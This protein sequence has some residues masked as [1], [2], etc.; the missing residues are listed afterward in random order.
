MAQR[1]RFAL[2]AA[3]AAVLMTAAPALGE[4][5]PPPPG[6]PSIDQYVETIPRSSGGA[7]VGVGMPRVTPLPRVVASRLHRRRDAVAERLEEVA[8]SSAWG[9][10]TRAAAPAGVSKATPNSAGP[11]AAA[12]TR[13]GDDSRVYW[14]I[15]GLIGVTAFLGVAARRR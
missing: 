7:P 2:A 13:T 6:T 11:P 4:E 9:A 10:P 3:S 12:F 5:P 8:T 14:L 15:A 1:A